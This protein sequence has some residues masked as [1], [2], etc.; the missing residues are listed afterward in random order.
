MS[1][2]ATFKKLVD[3]SKSNLDSED[4]RAAYQ[5][6]GLKSDKGLAPKRVT[7]ILYSNIADAL[8]YDSQ[9]DAD[10]MSKSQFQRLES[11]LIYRFVIYSEDP[12]SYLMPISVIRDA[13][14]KDGH[15]LPGFKNH[16]SWERAISNAKGYNAFKPRNRQVN[17]VEL[18]TDYPED[19]DRA[20][21][22]KKLIDKG[23]KIEIQDSK[24]EITHGLEALV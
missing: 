16:N 5:I 3:S 8:K 7:D 2:L 17:L 24:I 1:L 18:R 15:H 22:V 9:P 14:N 6:L 21:S 4:L 13:W 20:V 23:C 11:E 12:S 19:F 10:S